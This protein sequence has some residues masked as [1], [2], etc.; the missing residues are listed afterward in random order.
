MAPALVQIGGL[1]II[2]VHL[3]ILDYSNLSMITA[4]VAG[5][6][7]IASALAQA[8]AMRTS[9]TAMRLGIVIYFIPFFFIFNPALILQGP[10]LESGYLFAFC[11]VGILLIAGGLEGYLFGIGKLNAMERF[12]AGGGGFLIAVPMWATTLIG[13]GLTCLLLLSCFFRRKAIRPSAV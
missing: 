6:A 2:A 3:F 5:G 1:N 10:I 7:F 8:P 11:L 9:F 13:I 4:P 12:L